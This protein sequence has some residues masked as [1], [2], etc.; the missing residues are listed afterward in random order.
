LGKAMARVFARE[1]AKVL[2]VDYSGAQNAAAAEIGP[3]V[4]PFHADIGREEDIEAMFAHA[5]RVYG[6]VDTLVNNAATL[7]GIKPEVSAE[8]YEQ[9]TAV[10]LRGLLL[11]CKHGV[12]AM[13]SGGGSIINITTAGAFNTEDRAS[14]MYTAAKAAVHSLTKS[15]AVHHGAQGIRVNAVAPGLTITERSKS[16]TEEWK[17]EINTKAALGR[18]AETEEPAEVVAFLASDRASFVTGAII[19]VDGGWSARLA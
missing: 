9:M 3:S 2:A 5:Q 18:P 4:T 16:Y 15:F 7:G 17:R 14:I 19:P 12:R 6:R 1:G 13:Q 8:E 10:N 11:C